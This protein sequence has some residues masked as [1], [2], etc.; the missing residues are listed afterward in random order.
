M[1]FSPTRPVAVVFG[2]MLLITGHA[3]VLTGRVRPFIE[4]HCTDCHDR[5]TRKGGLDLLALQFEPADPV[6]FSR[7]VLIYDRVRNGEMPPKKKPRSR[8]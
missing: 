6:N 4:E 7:W 3:E 5:D 2:V 1:N 8:R